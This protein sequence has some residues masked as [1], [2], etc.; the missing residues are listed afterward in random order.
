M[1]DT[2]KL[3]DTALLRFSADENALCSVPSKQVQ[4]ILGKVYHHTCSGLLQR[5]APVE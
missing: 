1:I 5:D 4:R 2:L 3:Y